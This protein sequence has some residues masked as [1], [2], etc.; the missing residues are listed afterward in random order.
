VGGAGTWVEGTV[1][2]FHYD[3]GQL[4]TFCVERHDAHG[5][6]SLVAVR[7]Q[8]PAVFTALDNGAH[9]G[10]HGGSK[11]DATLRVDTVENLTTGT[12]VRGRPVL[13]PRLPT[14]VS[15]VAPHRPD[16]GD[17]AGP[18][19]E[20]TVR[21]PQHDG[22]QAVNSRIERPSARANQRHPAVRPCGPAVFVPIH[23]GD[24]V[25]VRGGRGMRDGTLRIDTVENLTTGIV[26]RVTFFSK[27]ISAVFSVFVILLVLFILI[28]LAGLV[29][30]F[31]HLVT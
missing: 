20:G 29:S 23:D 3:G 22:S 9:V 10:V 5:N 15:P 21:G 17:S 16:A 8:G 27:V 7:M 25:R 11:Q 12:I 1:R 26:V 30:F 18:W 19:A 13:H 31:V 6:R 14:V 2:D 4:R 28:G 24:R